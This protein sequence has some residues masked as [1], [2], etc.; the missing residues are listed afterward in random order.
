MR[1]NYQPISERI[2][3]LNA[4][5]IAKHGKAK[6]GDLVIQ[7]RTTRDHYINPARSEIRV[8]YRIGIARGIGRDGLVTSAQWAPERAHTASGRHHFAGR[9]SHK[10]D[11]AGGFNVR[12]FTL[13][14]AQVAG[15]SF[16]RMVRAIASVKSHEE[17]K[18]A[19]LTLGV[20][21][22]A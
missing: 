1:T 18:S 12:I 14:R 3:A 19:M 11:L 6:R 5:T 10:N 13:P 21:K 4:K 8:E 2:A 17:L 15:V 7:E 22:A 20:R 9:A 16:L